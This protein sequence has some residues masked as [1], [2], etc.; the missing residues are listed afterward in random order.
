VFSGAAAVCRVRCNGFRPTTGY[1]PETWV[2]VKSR[3][4]GHSLKTI[5]GTQGGAPCPGDQYSPWTRRPHSSPIPCG[6]HCRSLRDAPWTASVARRA[7]SGSSALSPP[8]HGV[9]RIALA[10]RAPAPIRRLRT[11]SRP[12][13]R[14]AVGTLHGAPSNGCRSCPYIIRP[15]RGPGAP[16]SATSCAAR[17]WSRRHDTGVTAGIPA[18]QP[19]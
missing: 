1:G 3:D 16:R 19:H 12:S 6:Q 7:R 8:V 9:W 5:V 13:S 4:M 10:S 2:T 14:Y 11:S 18:N 15:G 17:A